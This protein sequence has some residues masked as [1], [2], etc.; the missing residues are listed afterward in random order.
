M[1]TDGDPVDGGPLPPSSAQDAFAA[2]I[3][4]SPTAAPPPAPETEP[5]PGSPAQTPP[6]TRPARPSNQPPLGSQPAHVTATDA[7]VAAD[8]VGALPPLPEVS[9]ALYKTDK[10]IARGGMGR[11]VAA[12]DRR[13]GRPVA[14]KELLEPSGDATTRFQR[15]ALITAR[16]QHPGIVPVY[17]AGRWPSGE[18]FFAM[19]LVAGRPL[20]QVIAEARTLDQ[21]IALLPRL[22]AACDAIAYAH[23]QRISPRDLKPGNI[24]LGDFGETVVIDWGLAKDLDALDG[25]DSANRAPRTP[26]EPNDKRPRTATA[27]STLTVAGAVMGTPAY[28]APEQAR[29][30]T[31]DQRADVFA[32]GAM[33]Y[34]VLAGAPPYNARTATDVI[35]AAAMGRVVP[36]AERVR[37]AP[38][39]LV[40]IVHRAMRALPAD[41]YADAGVFAEELRR[42]MTGKLVDAHRYTA[43]QRLGRFVKKHRGA[44][45]IAAIAIAGFAVGGTLA[46]R[47]IVAERDHAQR[48]EQVANARGLAAERLVDYMF[49]HVQS[50]LTQI[51][52]LDL[53]AGLSAEV[54]RYYDRLSKVP[55]GMP[56]EDETR[57]AEAI[58]LIGRAEHQSG[59][60]DQALATWG[61]AREKLIGLVGSDQSA[62]TF[63]LR[64]L[65]AKLDFEA[66]AIFQERAKYADAAKDF[67]LARREFE[68][69]RKEQP[70]AR[71]LMLA[72]ADND[73]QLGD[74]LR[75]EGKIDEALDQYTAAK[76]LRDQASSQGNGKVTDEVM[77]LS[78]S[79]LKLGSIYQ[80]RG[81]SSLALDEYKASLRL[82]D[83]VLQNEPDNAQVQKAVLDTLEQLAALETSVGDDPAAIAMYQ[84]ALPIA[85]SLSQ[86]DPTNADWQYQRGNLLAD[87][88]FALG[89]SGQ[90]KAGGDQL[91]AAI[92]LQKDLVA[93]DPKSTR[94]RIALSRSYTRQGDALLALGR[95]DDAIGRYDQA[96]ELRK[97]LVDDDPASVAF[98]RS[99][100]WCFEKLAIARSAKG[101][102]PK[103]IEQHEQALAI[104][105]QLVVEAPAQ[106]GFKNELAGS[107]IELGRLLAPRDPKRAGELIASGIARARALIAAD[108]INLEWK[109][110]L[111]QG[112]LAQATLPGE[113]RARDAALAEAQ[114]VAD[115]AATRA[116][117]NV[118]WAGYLA[119]AYVGLGQYDKA[120]GVLAPLAAA[121]RLPATRQALLER[122]RSNAKPR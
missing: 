62:A 38:P 104:R 94:Y 106:G 88:G 8:L 70:A 87:L 57:M 100:A 33:L 56:V 74:M 59:K 99:Y 76:A 31:V 46:V 54:K 52:R 89:E 66:G 65:V 22:V 60:P 103:A 98:R 2:T 122:A 24:L 115:D 19:K 114:Q 35:A 51:G 16:L 82:R 58:E 15:E 78:T 7:T 53:M 27:S 64:T 90:F 85:L 4:P 121:G 93:K 79:H 30:E 91:Q 3:A 72:S 20:D 13:L 42:F 34:H 10:E 118:I 28:M 40:A 101:D 108:P 50:Q 71:D 48:A 81:Q 17:E 29:G 96:A 86:R 116:P 68:A 109:E 75:R 47:R 77:A 112:L 9:D 18:P 6:R 32:L 80:N 73:D 23:S 26:R 41:R 39:E 119:E 21:R 1:A 102:A 120:A 107:E 5:P 92:E 63:K 69:L 67:E 14:L 84:R 105:Q 25:Y 117:E 113:P 11:I 110:T 36:L 55:G 12:E 44:V 45:T 37:R 61:E 111:T 95:L 97:I 49:S 83:S 43:V